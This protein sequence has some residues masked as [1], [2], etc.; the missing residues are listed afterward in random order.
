LLHLGTLAAVI[1]YY[2]EKLYR[3]IYAILH[4]DF[5]GDEGKII[6]FVI[7]GSI[8]TAIIGFAFHDFFESM[9]SSSLL[10]GIALILTGCIL[11][12]TRFFKGKRKPELID[13]L[14]MGFAQGLAV[15]PG[16]SR[17]GWTISTGV[18]R[19]VEKEKATDYSFMLSIPA[20]IGATIIEGRKIA[21]SGIDWAI[22]TIG[23]VVALFVGYASIA[24]LIRFVKRGNLHLFA[25]YCWAIGLIA[26]ITS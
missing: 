21:L 19:G 3:I 16:I 4:V 23:V 18:I 24:I 5:K 17:S 26:I 15:A 12:A 20:L 1:L 6:L 13:A 22:V 7:V 8:P 14:F 9:F 25:F 10:V 2:R 11:F